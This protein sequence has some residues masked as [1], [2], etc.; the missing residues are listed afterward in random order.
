LK[1]SNKDAG[2]R[3]VSNREGHFVSYYRELAFALR[4][5]GLPEQK[6]RSTLE[7]VK[8]HSAESGREPAAEFGSPDDFA[9]RFERIRASTAGRRFV[10]VM[11]VA[12]FGV[13]IGL[14][15]LARLWESEM[16]LGGFSLPLLAGL[17]VALTG[18]LGGFLLDRRLPRGFNADGDAR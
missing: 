9:A 4:V 1:T 2:C 3:G 17:V 10:A 14:L 11:T 13:V 12:A 18:F 7:D 16:R 5:R 8:S 6:I 15:F